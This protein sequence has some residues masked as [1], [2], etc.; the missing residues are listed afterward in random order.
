MHT[1]GVKRFIESRRLDNGM[2]QASTL[3]S[4]RG[5]IDVLP[6]NDRHFTED[7]VAVMPEHVDA[8]AAI[9]NMRPERIGNELELAHVRPVEY[10]LR[11]PAVLA[12][13]LLQEDH[14]GL[15]RPHG[16]ADLVE[17][18]APIPGAEAL[19]DVVRQKGQCITGFHNQFRHTKRKRPSSRRT[20]PTG[21]RSMRS[22][23]EKSCS[24]IASS[25]DLALSD[26]STASTS[27]S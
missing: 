9:G 13:D 24:A 19:V 8:I 5:H 10:P 16:F 1:H 23:I 22:E 2:Q 15:G 18:E 12:E 21:D 7:R 26:E 20:A 6:R 11:M 3:E 27:R 4:V 14:I 25:S 17:H